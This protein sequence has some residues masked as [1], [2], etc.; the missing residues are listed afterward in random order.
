MIIITFRDITGKR[1]E[2]Y[3]Q[4]PN[5]MYQ[6]LLELYHSGL[7]DNDEILMVTQDHMCLYSALG[8]DHPI[9][10]EDLIGFFG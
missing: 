2:I 7:D 3:E 10:L 1:K 6:S 9:T 4:T 5:L 8:N